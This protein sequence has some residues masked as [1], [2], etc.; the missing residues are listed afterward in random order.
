MARTPKSTTT[1]ATK[2]KAPTKKRAVKTA[3][4]AAKKADPTGDMRRIEEQLAMY[5]LAE[6]HV[7]RHTITELQFYPPHDKRRET[8]EYKAAHKHLVD[9][10]DLPCLVCGVRKSTLG[11]PDRNP[12]QAR[13]LETHHHVVEWALMNAVDVEKFNDI[14]R[15]NLAHRHPHDAKWAYE[16][17]FDEEKIKAWVDHSEH[18]LWVLCDVHHRARYL[19][20]HEITFPIWSSMNLLRDDFETWARA[21]IERLHDKGPKG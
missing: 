13:Q 18:N 21:E 5:R 8:P 4:S 17:P 14:L 20:I 3:A 1:K 11:D 19:G 12:Y 15:P 2:A 16:K 6:N 9:T 7:R 10:L